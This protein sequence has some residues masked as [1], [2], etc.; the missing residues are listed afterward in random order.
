MAMF[1]YLGFV[2]VLKFFFL[3]SSLAQII[4][5]LQISGNKRLS[6]ETIKVIGNIK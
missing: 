3:S 1:R 4:T 6:S 2:L 5:D